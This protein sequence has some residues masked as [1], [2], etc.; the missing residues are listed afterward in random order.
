MHFR[1]TAFV[2]ILIALSP[3]SICSFGQAAPAPAP[4]APQAEHTREPADP[5][6]AKDRRYA[7]ELFRN[8]KVMEACGWFEKLAPKLP[9]DWVVQERWADCLVRRQGLYTDP[10]KRKELRKQAWQAY[11]KLYNAGDHTDI[12]QVMLSMLSEDG[13]SEAVFSDNKEVDRFMKAG[14]DA[15]GQHKL[16]EAKENYLKA[17]VLNPNLYSAALFLGDVY[18]QKGDSMGADQWF[19]RATQIDPDRETAYRYWGDSLL[20]RRK[21]AEARE[22]FVAAVICNP[23]TQK[24][25]AGVNNYLR[26]TG[27]KAT[28]YKVHSPNKVERKDNGNVNLT[29]D[30]NSLAQDDSGAAWMAYD[31]S[32]AEW[33]GEKFKKEFPNEPKYR[34]TL[35]EESESLHVAAT[36]AE[37]LAEKGEKLNDDF[38]FL[39]R[40]KQAGLLEPYILITLADDDITKDYAEYRKQHR[41]LLERYLKEIVIP[42]PPEGGP[43]QD[44]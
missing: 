7:L 42:P 35:K 13:G 39:V 21:F 4:P 41:D 14:E 37:E 31:L 28:W 40:L 38:A 9:E 33:Q 18:Y 30:S 5:E 25:W 2:L 43:S 17:L 1:R 6:L 16:D 15:F 23:Y 19:L 32:R 36:V 3:L 10:E 29:V 24:V 20:Q 12:V 11:R 26:A 34:H 22:K 44:K 27:L 8:G